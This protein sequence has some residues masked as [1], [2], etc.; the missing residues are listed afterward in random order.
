MV[1]YP[2]VISPIFILSQVY[3]CFG[4]ENTV[5]TAKKLFW[6]PSEKS[7]LAAILRASKQNSP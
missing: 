2:K 1:E 6:V 7:W 4:K 3:M 5:A